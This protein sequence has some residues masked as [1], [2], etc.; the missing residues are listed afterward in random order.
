[1]LT[2]DL[3]QRGK[4]ARYDYLYRCIKEDILSGR[5]EKGEKLPSAR[6][7]KLI[8]AHGFQRPV[9]NGINTCQPDVEIRPVVGYVK[10]S[11]LVTHVVLFRHFQRRA[12]IAV[13]FQRSYEP[14]AQS[15]VA[16]AEGV[17]AR[18]FHISGLP[19]GGYAAKIVRLIGGGVFL[20]AFVAAVYAVHDS[21]LS[22]AE[23]RIHHQPLPEVEPIVSERQRPQRADVVQ[24]Q[25]I[26][27]VIIP[28]IAPCEERLSG[29][30]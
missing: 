17:K 12:V 4:L 9:E 22:E 23:L 21:L 30:I 29:V 19:R 25:I 8:V 24:Q 27:I 26:G 3:E 15:R 13:G 2:Y 14:V 16:V 20:D 6:V 11:Q 10:A 7:V 18:Q 1:M 28:L 5:L